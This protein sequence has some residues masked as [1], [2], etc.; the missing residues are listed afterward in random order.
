MDR[1]GGRWRPAA[2]RL[3]PEQPVEARLFPARAAER[4]RGAGARDVPQLRVR[5]VIDFLRAPSAS[6]SEA[7]TLLPHP[8]IA[9]SASSEQLRGARPRDHPRQW[10]LR[11]LGGQGASCSWDAPGFP[12]SVVAMPTEARSKVSQIPSRD[13]R[14]DW[15]DD[16]RDAPIARHGPQIRRELGARTRSSAM[17]IDRHYGR[18]RVGVTLFGRRAW[19]LRLPFVMGHATGAPIMPCT[20]ERKLAGA[21]RHLSRAR[22]CASQP[23]SRAT[24]RSP[25][26]RRRL[27][28]PSKA[29]S[30]APGTL[31]YVLPGMG[32]SA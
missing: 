21:F 10:S 32:R 26:R 14:P 29:D 6:D 24:K 1:P 8:R 27:R 5:F 3:R 18:D 17:L 12:L 20:V 15:S 4:Y 22:R 30:R 11:Q 2:P 31:G 28:R 23:I 25:P 9:P 7:A 16:H 19:F 13:T